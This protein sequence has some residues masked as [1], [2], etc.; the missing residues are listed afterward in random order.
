[1]N[2]FLSLGVL[3]RGDEGVRAALFLLLRSRSPEHFERVPIYSEKELHANKPFINF[4]T[5]YIVQLSGSAFFWFRDP[6]KSFF[7]Q[8]YPDS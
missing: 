4:I 6:V 8:I 2:S 5:M 3:V 7:C 1:M